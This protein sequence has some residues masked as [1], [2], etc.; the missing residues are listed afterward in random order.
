MY[1]IIEFT[2]HYAS[3]L[4][5]YLED[6]YK[7]KIFIKSIPYNQR[8]AYYPFE[9]TFISIGDQLY[10]ALTADCTDGPNSTLK[11]LYVNYYNY[12]K[13]DNEKTIFGMPSKITISDIESIQ[14]YTLPYDHVPY[15]M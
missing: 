4:K 1:T 5:A 11:K 10:D 8:G 6:N 2:R 9:S 3:D 14:V 7:Y 13:P 12:T 15:Y